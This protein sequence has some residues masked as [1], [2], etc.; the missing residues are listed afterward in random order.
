MLEKHLQLYTLT[1]VVSVRNLMDRPNAFYSQAS[2]FNLFTDLPINIIKSLF[3]GGSHR[4][5]VAF[6][7]GCFS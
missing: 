7:Y 3:V 2:F 5:L 6:Q 1:Y 4:K